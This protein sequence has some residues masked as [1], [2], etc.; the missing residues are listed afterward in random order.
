MDLFFI[1]RFLFS[2]SEQ[3]DVRN[4][5]RRGCKIVLIFTTNIRKYSK[6][7]YL[8]YIVRITHADLYFYGLMEGFVRPLPAYLIRA[9]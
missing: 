2:Y 7:L 8:Y 6:T 1:F 5:L 3:L 4:V 9:C